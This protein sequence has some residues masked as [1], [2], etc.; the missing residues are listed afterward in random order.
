MNTDD[1]SVVVIHAPA[2]SGKTTLLA[3][4]AFADR[5]RDFAWL[6]LVE[7]DNDIVTFWRSVVAVLGTVAPEAMDQ[8]GAAISRLSPD[9][10]STVIP[11]VLNGVAKLGRPVVLVLDD[12]QVIDDQACN[13]S[14][15]AFLSQLSGLLT[16]VIASRVEPPLKLARL[17]IQER[18]RFLS[19]SDLAFTHPEVVQ[20]LA[21]L[22][23]RP[24]QE[25]ASRLLSETD[26]WAAGVRLSIGRPNPGGAGRRIP[27]QK[28]LIRE[29]LVQEILDP[30]TPADR[31]LLRRTSILEA[32]EPDLC[33][34]VAGSAFTRRKLAMLAGGNVLVT[35][36]DEHGNRFRLHQLL[37]AA[38]Q[39]ELQ[40]QDPE[41]ADRLHAL[42]A[43]WFIEQDRPL[44]ATEHALQ[45]SDRTLAAQLVSRHTFE[46]IMA[47]QLRTVMRWL[48]S[49]DEAEL[50]R[51]PFVLIAA[52]WTAGF[53]GEWG[54]AWRYSQASTLLNAHGKTPDGTAS[55]E[56]A[57]ALMLAGL[58]LEG[59]AEAR[60]Q[61]EIAY[62]LE[63]AESPWRPLAASLLG[64]ASL[65]LGRN[66]GARHAL[67]EAA[68]SILGPPGVASYAMGQLAILEA[69]ENQ[70]GEVERISRVA[71]EKIEGL[72]IENLVSSGAAY[73]MH[74]AA[75]AQ[76]GDFVKASR[77]LQAMTPI[78]PGLSSAM[79]FDAFQLHLLM[80][81]TYAVIGEMR[82]VAVHT[83]STQ[84]Y[85]ELI[86]YAGIFEDRLATLIAK[87]PPEAHRARK[88]D[89]PPNLTA[90]ERDVLALLPSTLS[91]REVGSELFVSRNTV[92]TYA[93]NIYRKLGVSSRSAAV[94]RAK[95]LGML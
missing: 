88:P 87:T 29:F 69:S 53:R 26:G 1:A 13:D 17:T 75:A 65:G 28:D 66:E 86:G 35:S 15:S 6:S 23:I 12:Y 7:T 68:T 85:L 84:R 11:A 40:E 42:A 81:E 41:A 79:P 74:A 38:L 76:S 92:K 64:A 30:M 56:S 93:T 91:L 36:L 43:E 94:T 20:L 57:R 2:G 32:L 50:Q 3:H 72:G 52:A 8:A 71:I 46:M 63:E 44:E 19:E 78:L 33:D 70:W 10:T 5:A 27:A 18:A 47:G 73:V 80:A 61:A 83:E 4:W 54:D 34:R 49:F 14:V 59:I 82:A 9:V 45:V 95:D 55:F 51:F 77:R 60:T 58:G 22:G 25:V 31:E 39:A 48:N 67:A 37:R 62:R 24:T 90:R 89:D 16:V 21:R